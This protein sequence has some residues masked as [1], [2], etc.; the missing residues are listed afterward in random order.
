MKAKVFIG[1]SSESLDIAYALQ[2]NLE[3]EAE[4]TVWSQGIFE[5]SRYALDSLITALD[6]FDFGIFVFGA[7]DV[8]RLR[9]IEY[10][11]ARDNV[12]F[13][14]GLLTGKLGKERNFLVMPRFQEGFR[15]PT[16]LLGIIPVT[17]D[18]NRQDG[19]IG[20]ALGPACSKILK[21]I[22]KCGPIHQVSE[23]KPSRLTPDS[24]LLNQLIN[25]AMET[26][27]RAVSLP[28][29][30]EA[31]KMRV[32]IFRKEDT[33]LVCS[34]YWAPN[35][36]K[37]MV[38][39]LRFDITPEIAKKV[40]VVR[41]VINEEITRTKVS[42]LPDALER[43]TGGVSEDISFVLAA[44][45][46]KE[47]GSIWGSVDFD[48]SSEVAETFLSTEVSDATMFQLAQHLKIIFSL[49]K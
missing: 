38:G 1:S 25:S 23:V 10:Q 39:K 4:I 6:G 48:A 45:I 34:H 37:E 13:E 44:P 3:H 2:E 7:D 18:P 15:L 19:N 43:A 41:A 42:P 11:T 9:G 35:P 22:K 21:A 5:P 30:P 14:L 27:C 8:V 49:H 16:D 47:N 20:A 33:Q 12:V 31:I 24:P 46:F 28:Q 26:V 32:F 29:S 17:F 40:A 36:I